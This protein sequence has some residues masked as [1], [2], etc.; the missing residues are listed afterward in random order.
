MF[1][2]LAVDRIA[3][4]D[5]IRSGKQPSACLTSTCP[6]GPAAL[7]GSYGCCSLDSDRERTKNRIHVQ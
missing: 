5:T 1:E 4:G 3:A 7:G 2:P 6:T